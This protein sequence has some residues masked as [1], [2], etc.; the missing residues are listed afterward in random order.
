MTQLQLFAAD[1]QLPDSPEADEASVILRGYCKSCRRSPR[2][3]CDKCKQDVRTYP[4]SISLL[5]SFT[6]RVKKLEK[7]DSV[8][9]YL[10]EYDYHWRSTG[11]NVLEDVYSLFWQLLA[12]GVGGELAEAQPA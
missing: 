3:I 7:V 5:R 10:P 1:S 2:A 11:A 6:R 12:A 4:D 9:V 8:A